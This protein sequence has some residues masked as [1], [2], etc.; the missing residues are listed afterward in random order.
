MKLQVLIDNRDKS[1]IY[2]WT[3]KINGKTYIGS[4]TNLY[5]RLKSYYSINNILR[6]AHCSRIYK[7]LLKYGYSQFACLI[8]DS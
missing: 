5:R 4:S 3:N 6:S 7:A 2:R 1:G 8:R